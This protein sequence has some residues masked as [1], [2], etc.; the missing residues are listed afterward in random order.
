MATFLSPIR[1]ERDTKL[2]VKAL[3]IPA[4]FTLTFRLI[5]LVVSL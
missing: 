1:D 3:G 4:H 2:S 5:T